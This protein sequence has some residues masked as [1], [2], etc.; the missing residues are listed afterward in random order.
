MLLILTTTHR[1]ATNL[2]FL[3]HKHPEK[4]QQFDLP[5]GRAYVFYPEATEESCTAALLLDIDPVGLTRR[6]HK[7]RSGF[8]LYPFVND[9]PY[10]A[11]SFMSVALARVFGSALNG[12]S[13][14]HPELVSQPLPLVATIAALPSRGG[15]DLLKRLFEPLGYKLET[16]SI[17]L[18]A[19]FPAWG[20]SNIFTVTLHHTLPLSRLLQHLYILIP[21]LD[22]EKHYWVGDEELQKLLEKGVGWLS[23]HPEREQIVK[24]YLR[25][26]RSLARLASEHLAATTD[27]TPS[28]KPA[29]QEVEEPHGLHDAR[30]DAVF[31]VL[32]ASGAERVLDLGCGEGKLI[33]RLVIDSQFGT[34]V[35]TD[36]SLREL[37]RARKRLG[38][39]RLP[40]R[41]AKRVSLLHS[42]LLYRDLRLAGFDAAA[43]VEVI[44]HLEP[45]RLAT[46][47]RVL[48]EYT[49]PRTVVL[50][51]PN[52]DY[53]AVWPW[54]EGGLR[55]PDHRFEWTR[56][57]F[58]K[59]A[60]RVAGTY[61]YT[62]EVGGI[63]PEVV[64]HGQPSHLGVF[65]EA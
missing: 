22:D 53:N 25:H 31:G 2:G 4:T 28:E 49:R 64:L 40:E 36:V 9:R 57:E 5:F 48:F 15:V 56:A 16:T 63:G 7:Q 55:H 37:E 59:W 3:L 60:E 18:D 19:S 29:Q 33:E 54:L 46:L 51:T 8:A 30:L 17:P 10:V 61:G 20:E 38:P 44:E 1:P 50:T 14:T 39:D 62:V 65:R 35:G 27:T 11:S 42:S 12:T 24:R 41:V 32:K 58:R 21:V 43:L 13:R 6:P 45:F 34:I 26:Q 47:E 52:R 23:E